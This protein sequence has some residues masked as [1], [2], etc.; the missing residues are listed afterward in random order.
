M[1]GD[2]PNMNASYES[3]GEYIMNRDASADLLG[4]NSN[5]TS[6]QKNYKNRES[7]M[8]VTKGRMRNTSMVR[9]IESPFKSSRPFTADHL[10]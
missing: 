6:G 4:L 9:S 3:E 8:S 2:T 5:V 1:Y 7:L 10:S